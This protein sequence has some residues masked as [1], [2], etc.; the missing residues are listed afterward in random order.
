MGCV[1]LV[2]NHYLLIRGKNVVAFALACLTFQYR[3]MN[4]PYDGTSREL[5]KFALHLDAVFGFNHVH[6]IVERGNYLYWF[7]VF[8]PTICNWFFQPVECRT[9][10]FQL[11]RG[12][13][14][15]YI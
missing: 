3:H 9:K 7:Y 4:N 2:D 14:G 15:D 5:C 13:S 11:L 8:W 10:C 1:E 12:E 6:A